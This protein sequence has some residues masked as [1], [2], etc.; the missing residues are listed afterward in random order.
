MREWS[1]S[2]PPSAATKVPDSLADYL[3]KPEK[4]DRV[5]GY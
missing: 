2:L 3:G 5:A 4:I 1:D